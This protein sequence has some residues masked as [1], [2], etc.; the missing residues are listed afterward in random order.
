M[1]LMLVSVSS[2][3]SIAALESFTG[4]FIGL[5]GLIDSCMY[6]PCKDERPSASLLSQLVFPQTISTRL[7][8]GRRLP[9]PIV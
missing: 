1:R 8:P 6:S 5:L 4:A 2:Q 3:E 7:H 9:Q